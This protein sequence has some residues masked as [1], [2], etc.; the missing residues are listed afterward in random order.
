MYLKI[1]S[2]KG[3]D[4]ML[5][6]IVEADRLIRELRRVVSDL[7]LNNLSVDITTVSTESIVIN[8]EENKR[9]AQKFM[10]AILSDEQRNK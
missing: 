10:A 2:I 4:E 6:K 8:K 7:M 5:N 9:N 1:D 3:T